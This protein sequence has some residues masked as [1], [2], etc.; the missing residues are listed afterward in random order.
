MKDS[1]DSF[2][3]NKLLVLYVL[4]MLLV[5]FCM[6]IVSESQAQAFICLY[7]LFVQTTVHTSNI[8]M[9]HGIA[10]YLQH[11]IQFRTCT[12]EKT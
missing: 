10:L 1:F 4:L 7:T 9:Q 3:S 2:I 5:Q 12:L 6:M 8:V 11:C